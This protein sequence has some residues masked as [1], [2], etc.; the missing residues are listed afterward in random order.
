MRASLAVFGDASGFAAGACFCLQ[1][2]PLGIS[3]TISLWISQAVG[4]DHP[5]IIAGV[6]SEVPLP[7]DS[8][9]HGLEAGV[10]RPKSGG[11]LSV[12][13]PKKAVAPERNAHI[14]PIPLVRGPGPAACV[15]HGQ[16]RDGAAG[17]RV[18]CG[19]LG[20]GEEGGGGTLFEAV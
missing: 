4:G 14:D 5:H 3:R 8:G 20:I 13:Q 6:H 17:G 1:G 7:I 15:A 11:F 16:A 12:S 9:A 2:M 10:F 19:V 18:A